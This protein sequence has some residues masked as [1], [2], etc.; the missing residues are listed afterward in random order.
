MVLCFLYTIDEQAQE[1]LY[2]SKVDGFLHI[3]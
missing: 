2:V 1:F 3:Q